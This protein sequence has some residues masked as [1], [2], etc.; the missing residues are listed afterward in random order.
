MRRLLLL[1]TVMTLLAA[2]VPPEGGP[3]ERDVAGYWQLVEGT[4][5]GRELPSVPGY[6]V[7]LELGADGT[8]GGNS[9]C[10]AYSG[11]YDLVGGVFERGAEMAMTAIGCRPE[12]ERLEDAYLRALRLVDTAAIEEDG[13]LHL[14]GEGAELVFE[15]IEP[16]DPEALEGRW[17]IE[18]FGRG[19][20]SE[21]A[22]G[23]A[24]IELTAGGAMTGDTGCRPL[25]GTFVVAGDEVLM[26]RLSAQGDCS[27]DLSEQDGIVVEVLGDGFVPDRSEPG[28]MRLDS[29]GG[30]FLEL[31][32]AD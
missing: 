6:R 7:T 22:L 8:I 1:V 19:G 9:G 32:R 13:S 2:C 3:T 10:N 18:S 12:L 4:V 23:G 25:G 14:S 26:T 17:E 15:Q 28:E 29:R 27:G 16:I 20:R 11:T 30:A 31:R 21:T 24:Y 5:D